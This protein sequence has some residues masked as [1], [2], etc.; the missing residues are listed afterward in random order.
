MDIYKPLNDPNLPP[1][2]EKTD[3]HKPPSGKN[4]PVTGR[5]TPPQTIPAT[6]ILHPLEE[7][8]RSQ[9]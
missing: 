9:G 4:P 6:Q 8:G 7:S 5:I 1:T 3:A 2:G